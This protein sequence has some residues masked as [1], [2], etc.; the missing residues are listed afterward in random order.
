MN[1]YLFLNAINNLNKSGSGNCLIISA[2]EV[3]VCASLNKHAHT[4]NKL[5][6]VH[7]H[8]LNLEER[9]SGN[10]YASCSACKLKTSLSNHL[11]I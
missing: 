9:Y 2:R 10:S 6:H 3:H 7:A 4:L 1:Q 5:T 8:T 11:I